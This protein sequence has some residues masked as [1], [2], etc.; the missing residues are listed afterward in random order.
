MWSNWVEYLDIDEETGEYP[1]LERFEEADRHRRSATTR[2]STTT[3]SSMPRSAPSSSRVSPIDRDIVV[4]TDWMAGLWINNGF[5]PETRQGLIPNSANLIPRLQEVSFDKPRDYTLPWQGGFAGLGYNVPGIQE[6]LG[7]RFP[8]EP[9]SAIRSGAAGV[10]SRCCRRCATPW[11]ASWRGRATTRRTSPMTS[12]SR[13]SPP[14]AEQIDN[15]QIRQVAGNDYLAA[16]GDRRC[17]RCHRL[18]G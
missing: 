9:G 1:T 6:S 11:A 17:H 18:V 8:D 7:C 16:L 5:A 10:A 4:L 14:L 15:G 13:R 3:T 2:T 12:S